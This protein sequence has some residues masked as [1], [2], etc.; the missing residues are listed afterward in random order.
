MRGVR[1]D[2]ERTEIQALVRHAPL[3]GAR[4]LDIGCGDG[5]LTRRIAGLVRSAVG[6]DPDAEQIERA[7]QKLPAH[8]HH[9]VR[10][11]VGHAETLRFPSQ[12]FD[13]VI[14]SWSL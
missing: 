12:S 9:K 10:F 1:K 5:R 3:R 6:I 11:Q 14:L 13:A 2:P 8:L 7:R 4:V